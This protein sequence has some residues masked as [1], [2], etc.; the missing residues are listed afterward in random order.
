MHPSVLV[1]FGRG[2]YPTTEAQR[3]WAYR[4]TTLLGVQMCQ[5]TRLWCPR[6]CR[7]MRSRCCTGYVRRRT[8]R[9]RAHQAFD[10]F[11][12]N[13]EAKY[14]KAV[15]CLVK[16]S[17]LLSFYDFP[18]VHRRHLAT[19]N[20]MES[21]FAN[22]RLRTGKTRSCVSVKRGLSFVHQLAINAKRTLAAFTRVSSIDRRR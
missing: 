15:S 11:V 12:A 21:T 13:Y 1:D 7:A 8:N 22:I 14:P 17:E 5:H 2:V 9:T 18:A 6:A 20:S 4:S 16:D 10:P 3:C 19:T